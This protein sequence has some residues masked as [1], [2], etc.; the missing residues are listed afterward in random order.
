MVSSG[1]A[2]RAAAI[3]VATL[4]ALV[5]GPVAEAHG[6]STSTAAVRP[7]AVGTP[8]ETDAWITAEAVYLSGRP[9]TVVCSADAVEWARAVAAVGFTTGA[10]EEYYGFSLIR[11]GEMYLSPYV[12]GGLRL[13]RG[14]P[15]RRRDELQV[16]WS[17]NVLIHESAHLGRFS[18]DEAVAEACARIGLPGELHR[19]YGLPYRSPE[20]SRLTQA[21]TWFRRTQ[22]AAYQRGLC[23]AS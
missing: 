10:G 6:G 20:L 4:A 22:G 23:S 16:A 7:A 15:M 12:C 1:G 2:F 8:V 13:G 21:A 3:L 19:L 9:L 14:G 5:A 17:V 18:T 11:Q